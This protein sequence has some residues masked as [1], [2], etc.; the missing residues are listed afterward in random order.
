MD[1]KR[2][3][4]IAKS[5]VARILAALVVFLII[6][7]C[8]LSPIFVLKNVT[9]Q[10]NK[11]VT[12]D[13]IIR[14]AGIRLGENL[15]QLQTDEIKKNLTKDLRIEQAVVQR[16]FPSELNISITERVPLA[17]IQCDYGY[18]EMGRGGMVLDAHRTL[19]QMPVPMISGATVADLFVG[20][21]VDDANVNKVLNFLAELPDETRNALSEV[22]IVDTEDVFLYAGS[23]Q[24]RLGALDKL[25]EKVNVTKS[26]ITELQQAK[27][28]IEYVDARFDVYSVRLRAV[29]EEKND[30]H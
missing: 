28:P 5:S 1:E 18:L 2:H 24:I 10:G 21:V 9:V 27:R 8:A 25:S 7:L 14:I 19:R 13:D 23:V 17:M 29:S 30:A 20:D 15:F 11:F 16:S 26:V 12:Q 3:K 4:M 22:N 6:L